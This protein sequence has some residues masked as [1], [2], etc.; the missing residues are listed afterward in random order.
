MEPI[1]GTGV[2]AASLRYGDPSSAADAIS[3]LE[4]LGYSTAWIPD[5]GGDVFAAVENLMSATTA[6]TVATGILN[7]WM[8][9]PEE[10]AQQHAR[11][12]STHGQRFLMGIGVS[13]ALL[14]D[15]KGPGT[16]AKPLQ[17]MREFLD[18]LD[19]AEIPVASS[20]RMLAALGPK[21][22]Q[23][24]GERTSGSHPYLVTP[25]HTAVVR[26]ALG[27]DKLIASEQ[28]VVLET[29]PAKAR[30]IARTHLSTYS[31]LP[32][33][34][35]NW[36]RIGFTDDDLTDG[37]SDRLVDA[38]VAWGDEDA[39]LTRVQAHRDAGADH[40]CIQALSENVGNHSMDQ[41]RALAPVLV[42]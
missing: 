10:A 14:I 6:M 35:N 8:H 4:S 12:T 3:E 17:R 36:K 37:C 21:M 33:Y 41:W 40:V 29:D 7:L 39:I 11:L 9:T 34:T 16:Y 25:E 15:Q 2:W 1:T 5:V 22:L 28:A 31:L 23:L 32:N 42:G 27:P 24:A 13:H 38:F 26:A 30:A 20:D 18:G 19:A